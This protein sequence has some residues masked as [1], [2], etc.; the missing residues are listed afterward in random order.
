MAHRRLAIGARRW[1]QHRGAPSSA[2]TLLLLVYRGDK[3]G[4]HRGCSMRRGLVRYMFSVVLVVPVL[5]TQV[6]AAAAPSCLGRSATIVGS[7][8]RDRLE[9]TRGNDVIVGYGKDLIIG[10]GGAD[11]I[12]GGGDNDTISGGPGADR[13]RGQGGSDLIVGFAGNDAL[14]GGPGRD[15]MFGAA[16]RDKLRGAG[17]VDLLAGG[18]HADS[19]LDRSGIYQGFWGGPGDDYIAGGQFDYAFFTEASRGVRVDLQEGTAEGEGSDTLVG[20]GAVVGSPFDDVLLGDPSANGLWG[21]AGDDLLDGRGNTATLETD[22]TMDFADVLSGEG[23]NDTLIGD[24]GLTFADFSAG[25]AVT[26]DLVAGVATGQGRD[27]LS[28]IE[29][30]YGSPRADSLTGDGGDNL[31]APGRGSDVIDGGGGQDALA[32]WFG[33]SSE[34]VRVDLTLGTAE[35]V[36]CA[37]DRFSGIENVFGSDGTDTLIG[38]DQP[39]RIF[40]GLR[41]DVIRGGAG[42]DYLDGGGGADELDGGDGTDT[43]LKYA[44]SRSCEIDAGGSVGSGTYP[45]GPALTLIHPQ[46]VT[47]Y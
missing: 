18:I 3:A 33:V 32:F 17:G 28:G 10:R 39:N 40:G 21:D 29:A 42:D 23:G 41:P 38:D 5:A 31:F 35:S 34:G 14:N 47:R 1:V 11:R 19:L 46:A 22:E 6:P 36:C 15:T 2:V 16:G 7:S 4:D 8:G 44:T 37:A 30:V 27:E 43:C 13:I 20:I 45:G 25:G 9:G 26:V 12:C 24:E